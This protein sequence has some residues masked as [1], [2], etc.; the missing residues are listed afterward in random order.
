MTRRRCP[1]ERNMPPIQPS[2]NCRWN[3]SKKPP[4]NQVTCD[5]TE[6]MTTLSSPTLLLIG[7]SGFV[8]GALARLA[9]A[10]GYQVSAVTRGQHAIPE[11]VNALTADRH[12]PAAFQR[13][14]TRSGQPWD[15]VI[16]CIGYEQG[17]AQQDAAVF[18][19]LARQFIFISTDFVYDP[20]HR[21]YPQ[22]EDTTH[23][24]QDG[25]GW[26]KRQC[27]LELLK[28]APSALP[29]T[30]VRPCY[31]YGPGSQLGNLPMHR[32]DPQLIARLKAGETLR[33]VGGGH[34]LQHPVF[35]RDLA[36]AIL[37]LAGNPRVT[38][39]ILN[40]GGPELIEV[41]DYFRIVAEV[42][43]VEM[44]VEE[45]SVSAHLAAH[46]ED[47]PSCCN[48]YYDMTR[49]RVVGGAVPNTPVAAG[50]REQVESMLKA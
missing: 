24:W 45:L 9:L 6:R 30:I 12:D 48:R 25:Y 44:K 46:P 11:G 32:R 41:A 34:F 5:I 20:Y 4:K 33:L 47:A 7:G 49:L 38:G 26:K 18:P 10:Q 17:D 16:D 22:P 15:L 21:R 27:E 36:S 43:G 1:P 31:V 19:G 23:F 29:W 40:I 39:E 2:L 35:V 28:V 37:S 14:V 42:L 13:A 3:Q 8:S 50:L